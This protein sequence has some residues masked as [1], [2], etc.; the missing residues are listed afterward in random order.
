MVHCK[1]KTNDG[2]RCKHPANPKS[3]HGYCTQHDKS[4]KTRS[5]VRSKSPP[6]FKMMSPQRARE[7]LAARTQQQAERRAQAQ[8]SA[9]LVPANSAANSQASAAVYNRRFIGPTPQVPMAGQQPT[10]F[11]WGDQNAAQPVVAR[12][13]ITV[14]VDPALEQTLRNY[15]EDIH[16]RIHQPGM[17][18][19]IVGEGEVG[20]GAQIGERHLFRR[21]VTE[22]QMINNRRGAPPAPPAPGPAPTFSV[23]TDYGSTRIDYRR[24]GWERYIVVYEEGTPSPYPFNHDDT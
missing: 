24:D 21:T 4:K 13:A 23:V 1:C 8:R 16:A 11:D 15:H 14:I 19:W 9:T 17:L 3:K 2:T 12:R 7:L 18:L 10:N 20:A 22:L 5:R 6:K